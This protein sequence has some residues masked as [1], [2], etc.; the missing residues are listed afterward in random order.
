MEIGPAWRVTAGR[1]LLP[2]AMGLLVLLGPRPAGAS[3]LP[4]ESAQPGLR[5]EAPSERWAGLLDHRIHLGDDAERLRFIDERL[6]AGRTRGQLWWVGWLAS[7]SVLAIGQGAAALELRG[8]QYDTLRPRLGVSAVSSMVGALGV[9]LMPWPGAWAP[10]RGGSLADA[11][12]RL[13]LISDGETLGHGWTAHLAA[14]LVNGVGALVLGL[15]FHLPVDAAVGF[16]VGMAV[17][18]LQI[19]TQPTAGIGDAN[20][21]RQWRPA[22]TSDWAIAF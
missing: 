6:D 12:H 18:E 9:L 5:G 13:N 7:F 11:E 21:Y 14:F 15:A 19:F 2:V 3:A 8:A 20:D 10:A 4:S 22:P 16:L 1:S 17:G